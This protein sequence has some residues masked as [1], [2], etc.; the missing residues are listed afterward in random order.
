MHKEILKHAKNNGKSPQDIEGKFKLQNDGQGDYIKEWNVEGLEQPT[1]EE[2]SAL[3]SVCVL[4]EKKE[5]KK[6]EI[7]E[8]RD[9]IINKP[10]RHPEPI[11]GKIRE[12]D[13]KLVHHLNA[14]TIV[15][16]KNP[17]YVKPW[18]CEDNDAG[19][20]GRPLPML[21][22]DLLENICCHINARNDIWHVEARKKK[23]EVDNLSTVSEVENYMHG[24]P[25]PEELD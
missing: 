15:A 20:D 8:A 9:K 18:I 22:I 1:P 5:Q 25:T 21:S 12:I 16:K 4:E 2:L 10:Y 24:I 13:P 17:N 3:T 7:D 14:A 19:E 23:N 6:K 11:N